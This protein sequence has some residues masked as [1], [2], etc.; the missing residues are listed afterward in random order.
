MS[1]I[2]RFSKKSYDRHNQWKKIYKMTKLEVDRHN[3]IVPQIACTI[4]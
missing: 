1:G 3:Q 2:Q 4:I